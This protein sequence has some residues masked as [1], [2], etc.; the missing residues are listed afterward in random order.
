MPETQQ[1]L[2]FSKI[3]ALLGFDREANSNGK[4]PAK[5]RLDKLHC[6]KTTPSG[7]RSKSAGRHS[8]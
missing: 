4:G 7:S 1:P 3:E 2:D 8:L 6:A 5:I